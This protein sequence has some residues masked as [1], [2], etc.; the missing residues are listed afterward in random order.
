M[1]GTI[2]FSS[3]VQY[4]RNKR[5]IP[6][7][8]F[9]SSQY[10]DKRIIV[11]SKLKS[12]RVD[13]YAE[14]DILDDTCNPIKGA[15]KQIIGPVNDYKCT[16]KIILAKNSIN[17]HTLSV[18]NNQFE[19]T[20]KFDEFTYSI[21]PEGSRDIDDAFSYDFDRNILKIHITDLSELDIDNLDELMDVGFT[22]YDKDGN[23]NMLPSE[24]SEDECSLLE[25]Q[26]RRCITMKINLK[27]NEINFIKCNIMVIKNLS[28]DEAEDLFDKDPKWI[29]FK[30][31]VTDYI[32][33]FSDTHKF[34]EK[35]MILYNTEFSKYLFD[36]NKNYPIRIHKGLK[37]DLLNN[38]ELIDD[39][40]KTRVCY[41]AAEYVPVNNTELTL[42]K[43]LDIDKYTHASSP[44][45][46]FIDLI[47]QRIAFNNLNIDVSNLCDRINDR[48]NLLKNAYREIKLLDLS[49][50]LKD[51]DERIYDA[52]VTGF[53]AERIKV[54]IP[55]LDIMSSIRI[56][57]NR[58]LK[59]LNIKINDESI[60]IIHLQTNS[61]ISINLY[62]KIV[63]KTM[64][65]M[66]ES[67][68]Y[69]KIQF[70]IIDPYLVDLLD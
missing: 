32:G 56:F 29:T 13:H 48:N 31:K 11:A 22:F 4:G 24:I 23:I 68:L 70:F 37:E 58:I 21:D 34:I 41:H 19:N 46:R 59:V 54:Y 33:E 6:Y 64:V 5:N 42:H 30:N 16:K 1:F 38:S 44:L 9:E 49:I 62:Q 8:L 43:A 40:L 25:G 15:I 17:N 20:D 3:R 69:K 28:Y 66:Y 18:K 63:V 26:I 52:I 36:Q 67:R 55:D 45:R 51:S 35:I 27:T 61:L 10:N 7:Y 14:I 53:D 57:N 65:K 47:N 50:L 2:K 39:N 12:D 60:D